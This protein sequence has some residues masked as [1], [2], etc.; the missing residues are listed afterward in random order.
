MYFILSIVKSGLFIAVCCKKGRQELRIGLTGIYAI[1]I[2][3][4]NVEFRG[5]SYQHPFTYHGKF[6]TQNCAYGVLPTFR[7]HLTQ[8]RLRSVGAL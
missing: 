4:P 6:G 5:F 3:I 2:S 8:K 7:D 1:Y